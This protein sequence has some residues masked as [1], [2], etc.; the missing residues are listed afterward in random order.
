MYINGFNFDNDWADIYNYLQNHYCIY[1]NYEN[2]EK[3]ENYTYTDEFGNE[4]TVVDGYGMLPM[5]QG[6][7]TELYDDFYEYTPEIKIYTGVPNSTGTNI[8]TYRNI[9]NWMPEDVHVGAFLSGRYEQCDGSCL[10]SEK[11]QLNFGESDIWLYNLEHCPYYDHEAESLSTIDI[12][13]KPTQ[14]PSNDNNSHGLWLLTKTLNTMTDATDLEKINMLKKIYYSNTNLYDHLLYMMN[15]AESKRMYDIYKIVFESFMETKMNHDFYKL[16]TSDGQSIYTDLNSEG[17]VY[18]ITQDWYPILDDNGFP[19]M[20]AN[21]FDS[22]G[23][24]IGTETWDFHYNSDF[25]DCYYQY[26]TSA[27]DI[28]ECI[29][30]EDLYERTGRK[31]YLVQKDIDGKIG[32]NYLVPANKINPNSASIYFDMATETVIF[33]T[34]RNDPRIR[35]PVTIDSEGVAT[36]I[37]GYDRDGITVTAILDEEH[38][39]TGQYIV[40]IDDDE[41]HI[42]MTVHIEQRIASDYYEFLQYRNQDL[43]RLLIDIKYNYENTYDV[44][45]DSYV[46]SDE[47]RQRIETL[48][49]LVAIALEKYFDKDEWRLLFN[50]L[51][52]SN[53]QNIQSYIMKM[54]LFF[55]SWKTQIVDTS[56]TYL[57]DDSY[58]NY[59]QVLDDFYSSIYLDLKEKLRQKDYKYFSNKSEYRDPVGVRDMIS[60][61]YIFN[62]YYWTTFGFGEKMYGNHFD[63]PQFTSKLSLRDSSSPRDR[64]TMTEVVFNGEVTIV[65]KGN[66]MKVY[67]LPEEVITNE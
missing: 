30:N 2:S 17:S 27:Q 15:H 8:R 51:P 52:T 57:L 26:G 63:Y 58:G 28:S 22:T 16:K 60:F 39:P 40:T 12:S 3:G 65:D 45:T 55:K 5:G 11:M 48:C 9:E 53:I 13:W 61:D 67:L 10:T 34:N 59:V 64:V 36:P 19:K 42:E 38:N 50:I 46:P 21:K 4:H 43:Y 54:V 6:W 31:E 33:L 62:K 41:G 44:K 18:T 32:K 23:Y 49:E 66:G 47:K 35:I 29:Y 24:P 37:D 14:Y 1:G 20:F 7:M 56:I 25:T